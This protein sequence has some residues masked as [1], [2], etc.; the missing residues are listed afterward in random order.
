MKASDL[1]RVLQSRIERHGD[2]EVRAT[3]EGVHC[4]LSPAAVF[5]A[6]PAEHGDSFYP[7]AIYIDAEATLY[8]E[9]QIKNSGA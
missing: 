1:I 2:R 8:A 3:Y 7:A 5:F 6:D 4:V 9:E